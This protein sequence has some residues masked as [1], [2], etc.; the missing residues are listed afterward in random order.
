MELEMKKQAKVL[1]CNSDV[2]PVLQNSIYISNSNS[3][4]NIKEEK[5]VKHKY[6]EYKNVLLK[7]SELNK[8][9]N[10]YPLEYDSFIKYLDEYIEMKGAKYKSHY[11]AIKKWVIDATR[12]HK[13][14]D[15]GKQATKR[16]YTKEEFDNLFDNIDEIN[17]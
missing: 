13:P 16:E 6:G 12:Q 3:I 17:I 7:D 8:L 10:D 9:R 2:T 4:S 1:Q 14:K 15:N 11:L 5:E